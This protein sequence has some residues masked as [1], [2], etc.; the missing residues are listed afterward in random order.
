MSECPGCVARQ[1]ELDDARK[2]RLENFRDLEAA[3]AELKAAREV[4]EAIRVEPTGRVP[5]QGSGP[6]QLPEDHPARRS[7]T[8]THVKH[9]GTILWEEHVEAWEVYA[10]RYGRSQSAERIAQRHG[11]DYS[12]LV[13]YLGRE[14][15][16]WRSR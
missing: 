13:L 10:K 6:Y 2:L 5:V 3:R 7:Y 8:G 4:I 1:A 11:F 15:V 12:E 9:P 14:P 16:S